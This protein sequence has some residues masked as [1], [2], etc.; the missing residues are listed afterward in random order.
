M[1]DEQIIQEYTD[2]NTTGGFNKLV[3]KCVKRKSDKLV[4]IGYQCYIIRIG[5]VI[6]ECVKNLSG[7]WSFGKW[8]EDPDDEVRLLSEFR[9]WA[10]EQRQ[11]LMCKLD[12]E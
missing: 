7:Y 9:E 6:Y 4:R 12:K 1:T 2:E 10:T 11:Q 8:G 3:V 5:D